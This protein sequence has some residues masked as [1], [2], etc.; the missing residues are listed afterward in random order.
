MFLTEKKMFFNEKKSFLTIKKTFFK[1]K[2]VYNKFFLTKIN[3]DQRFLTL[4][5]KFLRR[6]APDTASSKTFFGKKILK[7]RKNCSRARKKAHS[8]T[9]FGK[10]ILKQ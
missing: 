2:F 1:K 7:Q 5:N 3:D 8:K 9:F 10:K 6:T 4:R